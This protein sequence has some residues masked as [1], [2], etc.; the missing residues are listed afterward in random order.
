MIPRYFYIYEILVLNGD[1]NLLKTNPNGFYSI[2]MNMVL[3]QARLSDYR[4]GGHND[5]ITAK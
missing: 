2:G 4:P 1:D 3:N 5:S